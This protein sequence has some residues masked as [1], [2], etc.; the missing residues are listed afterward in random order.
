M[1]RAA[2]DQGLTDDGQPREIMPY[3]LE[4]SDAL[5]MGGPILAHVGYLTKEPRYYQACI[6]HLRSMRKLVLR[7]DGLY[8]HSPLDEA[9][10]GRG[11]GFPALG[12][13][14]CLTYWPRER[15]D[16]AELLQMFR[17]HM[18]ALLPHQDDEG[19]WHQVID[20]ADSY[21]ELSCTCMITW[22]MARGVREGWLDAPTYQSAIERGWSAIRLRIGPSGS[23]VDVCTGTGKQTSLEDYYHRPAILGPDPRG[24][25][26]CLLVATEVARLT[27]KQTAQP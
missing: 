2:A 20:R 22:A 7:P 15:A 4:M 18:A 12:L 24:G 10:W 1:A 13:A 8:R 17:D 21:R 27:G 23:L 6:Q 14:W 25:A 11:N 16:H 19:C 3:H 26:M 9:A 5:Y